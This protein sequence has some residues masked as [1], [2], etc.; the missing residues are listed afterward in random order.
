MLPQE[1]PK[2]RVCMTSERMTSAKAHN[3]ETNPEREVA[4]VGRT[5]QDRNDE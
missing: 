3:D 4:S 1:V 5:K 2:Q